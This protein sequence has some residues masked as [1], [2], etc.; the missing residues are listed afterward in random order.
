MRLPT[1]GRAAVAGVAL[2]SSFTIWAPTSTAAPDPTVDAEG[3]R[4]ALLDATAQGAP[5]AMARYDGP[6]GTVTEEAGERSLD[7]GLPMDTDHR[8]RVGSVTKTFT[9]VVLLQLI[10]E[11]AADLDDP[12]N[13]HLPGLLPDDRIT[14]RHILSHR[15]GLWDYSN[16]MFAQTVPG[17]EAVRDKVFTLQELV[18]LS[19]TQPLT[20]EP[21]SAYAYSNANF[22]VAGILIEHLT[23]QS[24]NEA[25]Q[26]RVITPLGLADTGYVHPDPALPGPH[27]DGHLTPDE[28][29]APLVDS[30]EQTVSWAQ[31]AGALY[32]TPADLNRFLTALLDGELLGP[33][34]LDAMLTMA[35]TDTTG[36]RFYGL[37]L[38]RY[39]LSC[40]LSV[41]GHTGT[42]QGYY[43]YAFTTEDG[44]RSLTATANASNNGTV[45]TALGNTL[46][47][48]F[49]DPEEPPTAPRFTPQSEPDLPPE[50]ARE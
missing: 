45:N 15:S 18:D 10:G 43:T 23:G 38:R 39:D 21:G 50:Q 30:T 3:I 42:V 48:A 16:D 34:E 11:G 6:E 33:D 31:S 24:L 25:Y 8:F 29:D 27:I 9:A 46:E 32:S 17:F 2:L 35:P 44:D 19:L 13:A 36:T 7:T 22:V 12:V 4:E 5:G 41:Y 14:L 28:A 47:A 1:S 37:G 49:C 20:V 40:E 26:E